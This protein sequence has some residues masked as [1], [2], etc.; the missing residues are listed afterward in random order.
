MRSLII[1][2]A[3]TTASTACILVNQLGFSECDWWLLVVDSEFI[4]K[5][6]GC[7]YH[8]SPNNI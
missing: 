2:L 6:V 5:V 1:S 7:I 8:V 3:L 4:G